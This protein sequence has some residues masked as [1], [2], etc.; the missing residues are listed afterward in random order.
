MRFESSMF[1]PPSIEQ[2][3][4]NFIAALYAIFLSSHGRKLKFDVK[5]EDLI[6]YIITDVKKL[7]KGLDNK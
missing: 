1:T 4:K 5:T 3:S 7:L 2:Y 6:D